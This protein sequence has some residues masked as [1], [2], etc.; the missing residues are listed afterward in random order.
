MYMDMH[1]FEL[2]RSPPRRPR[3]LLLAHLLV[4]LHVPDPLQDLPLGRLLNLPR[5]DVLVED[6]V[7]LHGMGWARIE[8]E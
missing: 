7:H 8:E 5:Q 6:G 2:L 4:V 3:L 1:T